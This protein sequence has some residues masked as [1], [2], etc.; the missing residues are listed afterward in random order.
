MGLRLVLSRF[1]VQYAI[2][3][4]L[5]KT[6]SSADL[7]LWTSSLPST[8]TPHQFTATMPAGGAGGAGGSRAGGGGNRVGGMGTKNSRQT[9]SKGVDKK[10][11][12]QPVKAIKEKVLAVKEKAKA[13][14]AE[15]KASH[16]ARKANFENKDDAELRQERTTRQQAQGRS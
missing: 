11:A 13:K 12:K 7:P 10:V 9:A 15:Q 4:A 3:K 5:D 6:R 8:G 1:S 16:D 14:K 2:K